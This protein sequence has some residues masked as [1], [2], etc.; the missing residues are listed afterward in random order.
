[1]PETKTPNVKASAASEP[2]PSQPSAAQTGDIVNKVRAGIRDVLSKEGNESVQF[3]LD[4]VDAT[5][6]IALAIKG[7]RTIVIQRKSTKKQSAKKQPSASGSKRIP[8]IVSM[9]V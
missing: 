7:F 3:N 1:M 2:S 4:Q 8:A 9:K 5:M 6:I